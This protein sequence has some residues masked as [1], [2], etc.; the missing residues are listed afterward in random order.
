[1]GDAGEAENLNVKRLAGSQCSFEVLPRVTPESE[2]ELV[3]RDGCLDRILMAVELIADGS[4]NE[5][6][7]VRVKTF[8]HKEID[9]TQVYVA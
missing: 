3:A 7:S 5:V 1:V 4:P 2:L 6:S 8:L 9:L